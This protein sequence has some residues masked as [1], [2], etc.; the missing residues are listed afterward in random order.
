MMWCVRS[1]SVLVVHTVLHM[2]MVVLAETMHFDRLTNLVHYKSGNR[3]TLMFIRSEK[4]IIAGMAQFYSNKLDKMPNFKFIPSIV[5]WRAKIICL[6]SKA[7]FYWST[8]TLS[9][10]VTLLVFQLTKSV[11]LCWS[12]IFYPIL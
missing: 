4:S 5:Q 10:S 3:T 7:S 1:V 6:L 12:Y 2:V 9:C 8:P 11:A